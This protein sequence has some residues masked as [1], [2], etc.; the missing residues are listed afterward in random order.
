MKRAVGVLGC[1]SLMT[2][3]GVASANA[4]GKGFELG[5]RTGYSL[6]IGKVADN[7]LGDISDTVSGVVPLWVDLGYRVTPHVMVGGY[8]AYGFALLAG[9]LKDSCDASGLDCSAHQIRLGAQVHYHFQ[10]GQSL[11]PW[12]G[13]GIG[14]EWLGET[15]SAGGRDAGSTL[16]G[17][18]FLNLQGGLDFLLGDARNFGLGPF[19]ALSMGEFGSVSCSTSGGVNPGC[20]SDLDKTVH[21]FFTF[22]VR[23]SFVP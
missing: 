4:E 2:Y 11:D 8:F 5:L 13:A 17:V 7:A 15:L 23:G 21:E 18:E 14:W 10:P 6:P 1:C 3:A 19:V 20:P 12:I 22:G 9:D 16:S